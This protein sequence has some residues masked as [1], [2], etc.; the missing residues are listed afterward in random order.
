M[1]T[2]FQEISKRNLSWDDELDEDLQQV[3][4]KLITDKRKVDLFV[5]PRYYFYGIGDT[6]TSS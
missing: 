6:I 5:I 3:W 1:K 2:L 4:L